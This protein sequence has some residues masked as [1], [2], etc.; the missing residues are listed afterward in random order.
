M[1]CS[2][3]GAFEDFLGRVDSLSDNII[4]AFSDFNQLR[5]RCS[6]DGILDDLVRDKSCSWLQIQAV[7]INSIRRNDRFVILS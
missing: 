2:A 3:E 4:K 7:E 5:V 1:R 6:E